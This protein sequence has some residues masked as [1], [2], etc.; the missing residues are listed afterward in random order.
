MEQA[1]LGVNLQTCC[2]PPQV[3]FKIIF[4]LHA[5]CGFSFVYVVHH[6]T[7]QDWLKKKKYSFQLV[8]D[9]VIDI[10]KQMLKIT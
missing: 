5:Q 3:S 7:Y 4:Q 9:Y 6:F 8:T 1:F 10:E 2:F